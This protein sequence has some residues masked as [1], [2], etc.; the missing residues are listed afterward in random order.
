MNLFWGIT[1][2]VISGLAYAGQLISAFWPTVA[3]TLGLAESKTDVD[4]AFYADAS[5]EAYWDVATLWTL[6]VAGIL[7]LLDHQW[8]IFLGLIGGGSYL[9]FAGRGIVVRLVMKRRSIRIG[10]RQSVGLGLF[11]LAVWGVS[12]IITIVLALRTMSIL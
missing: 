7:L 10:N 3:A 5:G 11:F 2:I 4:K 12:A 1:L 8:W 9:Y 6:P